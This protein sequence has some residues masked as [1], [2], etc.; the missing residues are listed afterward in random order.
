MLFEDLLHIIP[1]DREHKWN[2]PYNTVLYPVTHYYWGELYSATLID[3][4]RTKAHK[5]NI[6]GISGEGVKWEQEN[7][8]YS[9]QFSL[10]IWILKMFFVAVEMW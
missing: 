2:L 7:M 4:K 9:P 6:K 1:Q 5:C 8:A 3:S 10:N